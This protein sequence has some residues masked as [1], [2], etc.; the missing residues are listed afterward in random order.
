MR[1]KSGRCVRYAPPQDP[2]VGYQ[3][4]LS[5]SR[6][7][8]KYLTRLLF[9]S[10]VLSCLVIIIISILILVHCRQASGPIE[11][12]MSSLNGQC[13]NLG[14]PAYFCCVV[15]FF[16]VFGFGCLGRKVTGI[17]LMVVSVSEIVLA[18]VIAVGQECTRR[19]LGNVTWQ[20]STAMDH[21]GFLEVRTAVH[22]VLQKKK[23]NLSE[24]HVVDVSSNHCMEIAAN[25]R[26]VC[27][28]QLGPILAAVNG[29]MVEMCAGGVVD[30]LYSLCMQDI[31]IVVPI[32]VSVPVFYIGM[33]AGLMYIKH[34]DSLEASKGHFQTVGT[35]TDSLQ[36]STHEEGDHS[37][38]R[39]CRCSQFLS[40]ADV[41]SL[42]CAA[43]HQ[44]CPLPCLSR[45]KDKL[46]SRYSFSL[47]QMNAG[48]DV[49]SGMLETEMASDRQ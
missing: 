1:Q 10:I 13:A 32:L 25:V 22:S 27:G 6:H 21:C 44:L 36:N 42:K 30:K 34:V 11:D 3:M 4:G 47:Q 9:M 33:A 38:G 17:V 45:K 5:G 39:R 28:V 24:N 14:I 40:V 20:L 18:A 23:E 46:Q 19:D 29:S 31:E 7:T 41:L 43:R 15:F 37:H 35:N 26:V 16:T 49:V 8:L 48:D 2:E 12:L